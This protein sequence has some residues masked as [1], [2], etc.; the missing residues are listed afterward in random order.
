MSARQAL[1]F[2]VA[3]AAIIALSVWVNL[4]V[5]CS[6]DL[7]YDQGCGGAGVYIPLWEIFLTPLA[8]A[9]I[10]IERW[11]RTAPVTTQRIVVYLVGIAIIYQIGWQ[12]ERFPMLLLIEALAIAVAAF[13][14]WRVTR[15]ATAA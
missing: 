9:A 3:Y 4:A 5:F 13:A 6:G 10:G 12:L 2:I 8:L 1:W 14:R 15:G 7:K 11:R